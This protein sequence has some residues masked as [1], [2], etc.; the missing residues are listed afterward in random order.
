VRAAKAGY[1]VLVQDVR[2]RW[3]SD[4]EWTPFVNEQ[5]DGFDTC[6]WILEQEWCSGQIGMFGGSYVGLTQWQAAIA[7]APGLKAIAPAITASNYH[8]GWAYQGG[9]FELGF[10]MSW[11]LGL[12][13]NTAARIEGDLLERVLD[14]HDEIERAFGRMPQTGD[15]LL[16]EVAPYYDEWLAHPS[17][18]DFWRSLAP[19]EHHG[20]LDIACFH[21]G[22][23]YDIFLGGTIRNYV[24]MRTGAKSAWARDNQYLLINPRDHYTYSSGAAM[25]N[26]DPGIRSVNG[27]IDLDGKQLAFF[28]AVLRDADN[29]FREADRVTIFVMGTDT[30]RTEPEWPLAN[31]TPTDFYLSSGGSANTRDGDGVLAAA[32]PDLDGSDTFTY[33]PLNPVP[34]IGGPLCGHQ[35]KLVWGRHDQRTVEMRPDVLVYTSGV[36]AESIEITGEVS[37]TLF[38]ESSAVDTD[39][40]AKLVDVHPDGT[41][42]NIADGIIRARYRHSPDQE[43]FLIPGAVTEF[44]IDMT[45]TSFVFD[46]GHQ[47]RLD[48]SSSNY[49]RFDRN[50][51]TGG[52]IAETNAGDAIVATQIVHHSERYPSRLT[53]PIVPG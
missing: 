12:A 9:A 23:W 49:P 24:G 40:T 27:T 44:C 52:V 25:G 19:K 14:R 10:N 16:A 6:A 18:D 21:T 30:W 38:A 20:N 5:A 28:D 11:T 2:G 33:D 37:V 50:P 8:E 15:P 32:N 17:Y 31:V 4:G 39:F 7:Q 36:L 41:A 42:N 53:L 48:I 22:G 3:G 47:I 51:N 29:G 35:S 13:Q 43:E 26:Y 34:T 1:T 45:Y 46:A